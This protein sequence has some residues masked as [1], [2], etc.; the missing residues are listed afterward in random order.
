MPR[1]S[2][3]NSFAKHFQNCTNKNVYQIKLKLSINLF[4]T[5]NL[6]FFNED[7]LIGY[8]LGW[9]AWALGSKKGQFKLAKPKGIGKTLF[10]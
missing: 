6:F 10:M 4:S 3:E 8:R 7:G 5:S 2:Q 9:V 1:W